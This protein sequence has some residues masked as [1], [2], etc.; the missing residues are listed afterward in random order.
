MS[1]KP[2]KVL[3]IGNDSMCL[4]MI[5]LILSRCG[6][7]IQ[8]ATTEQQGLVIAEQYQPD[9]VILDLNLPSG[10]DFPEEYKA[11]YGFKTNP[12]L[13]N[14]PVLWVEASSPELVYA[15][16]KRMEASGYLVKPFAPLA[17]LEARKALLLRGEKTYYP[18]PIV[19]SYFPSNSL[20]TDSHYDEL[21]RSWY[22]WF[23]KAMGESSLTQLGNREIYRFL[24]LRTF[25]CPIAVVLEKHSGGGTLI[26]KALDGRGGYEPGNI[27]YN[28]SRPVTNQEMDKFLTLLQ[29]A[30]YWEL[31]IGIP[32]RVLDGAFWILEALRNDEYYVV[33]RCC[34]KSNGP[35]A[36]FREICLYLLNLSGIEIA[37]S[38]V[39]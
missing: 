38:E 35:D 23:L 30:H 14:V 32:N 4:D 10:V 31:P 28:V 36:A 13:Q 25:H 16:A 15:N 33:D 19:E 21:R 5:K 24:W 37:P 11:F 27:A 26:A 9:F 6:D 20:D 8:T 17:L 7:D 22:S 39:Y 29:N 18:Y 1:T 3:A 2:H 34:P 12:L